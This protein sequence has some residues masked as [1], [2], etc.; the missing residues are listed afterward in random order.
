MDAGKTTGGLLPGGNMSDV[1]WPIVLTPDGVWV[2]RDRETE[3]I[4]YLEIE[5]QESPLLSSAGP[6]TPTMPTS[7]ST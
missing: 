2:L 4:S 5:I 7:G 6:V 3:L 1:W